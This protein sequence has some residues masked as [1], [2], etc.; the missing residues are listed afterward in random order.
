ML[1]RLRR[2]RCRSSW[3]NVVP[4]GADDNVTVIEDADAVARQRTHRSAQFRVVG[5]VPC[6]IAV[7]LG[8]SADCASEEG[9]S[10]RAMEGRRRSDI[11][12]HVALA[13]AL[14]AARRVL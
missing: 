1:S 7:A 13:E 4:V 9:P 12:G 8:V 6:S 14:T 5:E 10:I 2:R 11:L 3:A